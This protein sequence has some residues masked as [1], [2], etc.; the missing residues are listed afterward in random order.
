MIVEIPQGD[1]RVLS[2]RV[3]GDRVD[4]AFS[5]GKSEVD[6][7]LGKYLCDTFENITAV[8]SKKTTKKQPDPEPEAEEEAAQEDEE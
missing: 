6:D 5:E 4:V 8:T 1:T 3:D 7:K 2:I